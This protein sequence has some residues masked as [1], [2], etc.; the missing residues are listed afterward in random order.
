MSASAP[1]LIRKSASPEVIDEIDLESAVQRCGT[2]DLTVELIH[3]FVWGNAL[4][5]HQRM[6]HAFGCFEFAFEAA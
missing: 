4:V 6:E 5:I 3:E 1:S 2:G